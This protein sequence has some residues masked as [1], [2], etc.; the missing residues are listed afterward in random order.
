MVVDL[1]V[2]KCANTLVVKE[3]VGGSGGADNSWD[4]QKN[5]ERTLTYPSDFGNRKT[6][7]SHYY[8]EEKFQCALWQNKSKLVIKRASCYSCW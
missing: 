8:E 5:I 6:V 2:E 4:P 1:S 3:A 7:E